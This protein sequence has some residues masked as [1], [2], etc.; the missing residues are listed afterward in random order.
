L[1]ISGSSGRPFGIQGEDGYEFSYSH[2]I[3]TAGKRSK[4]VEVADRATLLV[5]AETDEESRQLAFRVASRYVDAFAT[6]QELKELDRLIAA[7]AEFLRLIEARVKEG[8][9]APLEQRLVS[10]D[11]AQSQ[12]KR[13]ASV[14]RFDAAVRELRTLAGLAGQ[15]PLSLLE[16]MPMPSELFL[17][18]LQQLALRERADLRAARARVAEAEA[19]LGLTEAE[20]IPN[21]MLRG[22]YSRQNGGFDGLSGIDESGGLAPLEDRD[23]MVSFGIQVQ[24]GTKRRNAGNIEAAQARLAGA[25]LRREYAESVA[26]VEVENA[27]QR[28]QSARQAIDTFDQGLLDQAEQNA[29]II[30]EAYE[31][32]QLRLIDVL[33]EQ[34][35]V[36]EVRL[37]YI[38]ARAEMHRAVTELEF[39][40]GRS[41]R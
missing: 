19:Q 7:Y 38:E 29:E 35:R 26:I 14:T 8:D 22:T 25:S 12:A 11:L 17:S 24:L 3:E 23:D 39:A 32:G 10:V 40:V 16:P 31:L 2:E 13:T 37:A 15:E 33:N 6:Q 21:L 5:S 18:E 30:R 9:A 27:W 4:R 41:L 34:R 20:G 28:V 1:E 36:I